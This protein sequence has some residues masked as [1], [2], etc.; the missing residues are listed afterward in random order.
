M[1]RNFVFYGSTESPSDYLPPPHLFPSFFL[2]E[3][4]FLYDRKQSYEKRGVASWWV[5]LSDAD[6]LEYNLRFV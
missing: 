1:R 2:D 4:R 6:F 5:E 3:Q